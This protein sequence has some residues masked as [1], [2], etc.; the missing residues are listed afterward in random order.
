M[1]GLMEQ[2][3]EG[4]SIVLFH[5]HYQC[6]RCDHEWEDVWDCRCDDDCPVCGARHISAHSSDDAGVE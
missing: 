5:N 4:G 2:G 6:P 1:R 3:N